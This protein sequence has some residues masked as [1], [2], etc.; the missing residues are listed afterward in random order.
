MPYES[1]GHM[2]RAPL[3]YSL[4]MIQYAP[5]A[6]IADYAEDIVEALRAEYPDSGDYTVNG[7]TIQISGPDQSID[8]PQKRSPQWRMTSANGQFGFVFGAD[9]IVFHTTE[10]DH[11]Q[12]F[13]QRLQPVIEIVFKLAKVSHTRGMGI[14]HIDN[15]VPIDGMGFDV[16][17]RPGYLC[18]AQ[19]DDLSPK[20]SRVEFVYRSSL[21]DLYARCYL[22]RNH[23]KVPHDLFQL[24]GQLPLADLMA[25]RQ[26]QFVL[27]D[28]DHIYHVGEF[29]KF[30]IQNVMGKLDQLHKQNS[31]G[32]RAMV[33]PDA[34]NA[35]KR[36]E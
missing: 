26:D 5:V 19:N 25:E 21:G 32:F 27:A 4:A 20:S 13:A 30:E 28:T 22:L 8:R 14:R 11:F 3:V 36:D 15:I 31:M 17:L 6:R 16:L 23:P 24:A 33:T 34:I 12:S 9:R 2:P 7:I 1:L 10:Y 18:P 35:W 29:E